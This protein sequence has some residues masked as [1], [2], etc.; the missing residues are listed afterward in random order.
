M[1]DRVCG[2]IRTNYALAKPA[3]QLQRLTSVLTE[4][5]ASGRVRQPL[6]RAVGDRERVPESTAHLLGH[7]SRGH[8]RRL[9][10]TLLQGFV[11]ADP[12][13]ISLAVISHHDH[14]KQHLPEILGLTDSLRDRF[15]GPQI[16]DNQV[17]LKPRAHPRSLSTLARAA[18]PRCFEGCNSDCPTMMKCTPF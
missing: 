7:I 6:L 17:R 9:Q 5:P 11:P 1:S 15:R 13:G 8:E 4:F 18:W 2:V 10:S 16:N 14:R 3:G 12:N